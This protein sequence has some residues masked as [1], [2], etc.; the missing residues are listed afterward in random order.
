MP[1]LSADGIGKGLICV[2]GTMVSDG[3]KGLDRE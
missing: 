2:A 1:I 3:T